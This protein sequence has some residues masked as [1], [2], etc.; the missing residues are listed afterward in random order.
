MT[1]MDMVWV[2]VA[3]LLHPRTEANVFVQKSQ[4]DSKVLEL[5]DETIA[6]VMIDKHLVNSEDRQAGRTNLSRGGSRTRYLV[7]GG[8][9]S[10]RLYKQRDGESDAWDKIGPTHP[11]PNNIDPE[12]RHL[13]TWYG[14]EYVNA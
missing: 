13:V 2:V 3:S 8:N 1:K 5:F 14:S 11:H 9:G 4:I 12:Y 7:R 6:P 10:F